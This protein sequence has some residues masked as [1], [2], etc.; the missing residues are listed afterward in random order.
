M[1]LETLETPGH[2]PEGISILV[3]DLAADPNNRVAKAWELS[4]P[5]GRLSD[6]LGD[7]PWRRAQAK[8]IFRFNQSAIPDRH[9]RTQARCQ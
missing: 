4:Y 3:Y 5:L 2:T 6:P 1:R 9:W 8:F 7:V